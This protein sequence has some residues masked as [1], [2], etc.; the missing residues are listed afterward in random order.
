M[1]LTHSVATHLEELGRATKI[2]APEG[3]GGTITLMFLASILVLGSWSEAHAQTKAADSWYLNVSS[4]G[5]PQDQTLTESGAFDVYG[6]RGTVTSVYSTGGGYL[7]DIGAGLR[8][9]KNLAIG[10]GYSANTNTHD[11]TVSVTVPHPLVLGQSRAANAIARDLEHSEKVVHVNLAWM[12]PLRT[13]PWAS[14][15]V[16]TAVTSLRELET[17]EP[18]SADSCATWVPRS[19]SRRSPPPRGRQCL[20]ADTSGA[21]ACVSVSECAAGCGDAAQQ[22]RA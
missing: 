16:S 7:F 17:S 10:I 4:G 12:L 2:D 3:R 8:V 22:R 19:I 18:V 5:S 21:L 13:A 14:T 6:Q 9:W 11:G 1:A 20:L 15:L